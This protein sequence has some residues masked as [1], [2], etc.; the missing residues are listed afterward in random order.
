MFYLFKISKVE[1]E[2]Q[3]FQREIERTAIEKSR[4]EEW[5]RRKI[6]RVSSSMD[7]LLSAEEDLL[8]DSKVP[9][10]P[11]K[12]KFVSTGSLIPPALPPKQK[13]F[14]SQLGK[15]KKVSISTDEVRVIGIG[16]FSDESDEG[17]DDDDE[18][19]SR[20]FKP[21]KYYVPLPLTSGKLK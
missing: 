13:V 10:L 11:P 19:Q 6:S 4:Q 3:R 2:I 1:S 5:E 7:S 14:T 21:S 18:P 17:D 20:H 8:L 9:A 12:G 16:G 15:S